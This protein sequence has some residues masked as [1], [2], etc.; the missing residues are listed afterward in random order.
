[1]SDENENPM[2]EISLNE[3]KVE[4]VETGLP[5]EGQSLTNKK[6]RSVKKDIR[7]LQ[8]KQ[9]SFGKFIYESSKLPLE[10]NLI[11]YKN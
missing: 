9:A 1:M 3:K 7:N 11:W 2:E 5:K 4:D 6:K 8:T 10:K